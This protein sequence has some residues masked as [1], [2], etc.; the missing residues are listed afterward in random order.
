[1]NQSNVP[2]NQD[3]AANDPDESENSA[4]LGNLPPFIPN[5]PAPPPEGDDPQNNANRPQ[6]WQRLSTWQFIGEIAL[7][8]VGIKVA[9][10]YS[11]QLDQMIEQN[12]LS[13][14]SGESVRQTFRID[15]RAWIVASDSGTAP[16][17]TARRA[18]A[19]P[20]TITNTGKTPALKVEGDVVAVLL[21]KNERPEFIYTQNS[22]HPHAKIK[23]GTLFPN[24][25]E[26]VSYPIFEHGKA[27]IGLALRPIILTP[28]L[29]KDLGRGDDSWIAIHGQIEYW[30]VFG[31]YHWVHF[32]YAATFPKTVNR[33]TQPGRK[34]CSA[35]DDVDRNDLQP[36]N[37]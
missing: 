25:P 11:K 21:S 34:D 15:Q 33:P 18:V 36:E 30:D 16:K 29:D 24:R 35:Y 3:N 12:S 14:I 23:G 22:G 8:L 28:E 19:I 31:V 1:M 27:V 2:Q 10:I 4:A 6:W 13:R 9:C 37:K 20:L 32:C 5:G 26:T 7:L 17:L